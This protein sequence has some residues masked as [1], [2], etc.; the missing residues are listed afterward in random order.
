[1]WCIHNSL[2]KT[3]TEFDRL[4]TDFAWSHHKWV[5]G[6]KC[7]CNEMPYTTGRNLDCFTCISGKLSK[8]VY[9]KTLSGICCMKPVRTFITSACW[10]H[11]IVS[12]FTGVF[13]AWQKFSC[14]Q[15]CWFPT[16]SASK[17]KKKN[18]DFVQSLIVFCYSNICYQSTYRPH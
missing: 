2:K 11:R 18:Q 14:K 15:L 17:K 16:C 13:I 12:S 5:L 10:L 6:R 9:K 1:M 8:V 3:K 7:R 4:Q